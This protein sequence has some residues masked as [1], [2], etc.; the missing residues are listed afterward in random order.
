[1]LGKLL[2]YELFATGRVFLP[3]Y[4]GL[5]IISLFASFSL[6]TEIVLLNVLTWILLFAG[7]FALITITII[8]LIQ[9]F[10]KNLLRDEGYLMFTLPVTPSTLIASKLITACIWC[11]ASIIIGAIA[12]L[13]TSRTFVDF[14]WALRDVFH[15]LS[16][17][18]SYFAVP[19]LPFILLAAALLAQ[20]MLGI[21]HVYFSLAVGQLPLFGGYRILG[22]IA[23]YIVVSIVLQVV[24]VGIGMVVALNIE[25]FRFLIQ[26]ETVDTV[27]RGVHLFLAGTLVFNLGFGVAA[28]VGTSLILK[29]KL[30]L[31]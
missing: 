30:N 29:K 18:L 1:M 25:A 15:E 7:Y 5:L 4:A 13:I 10:Y 28:F 20:L 8:L 22:A 26:P 14:S 21:L 2:K 11:I 31:E 24:A 17:V 19:A 6:Q 23:T 3:M 12:I 16:M 27:W 9:R